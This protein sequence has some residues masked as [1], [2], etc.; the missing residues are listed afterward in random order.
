MLEWRVEREYYVRRRS[1]VSGLLVR[2]NLNGRT[3]ARGVLGRITELLF[4]SNGRKEGIM[5]GTFQVNTFYARSLLCTGVLPNSNLEAP[6]QR[7]NGSAAPIPFAEVTCKYATG[8]M[9]DLRIWGVW[10]LGR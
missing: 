1:H 7:H 9:R 4:L 2:T 6:P 8:A 5:R 3:S 10:L